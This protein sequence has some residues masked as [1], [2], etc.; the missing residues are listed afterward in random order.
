MVANESQANDPKAPL[1]AVNFTAEQNGIRAGE[2]SIRARIQCPDLRFLSRDLEA[3]Q[4]LQRTLL[5]LAESLSP[6][7]EHY[8]PDT[9][10]ID[11]AGCRPPTTWN[12]PIPH[13]RLVLAETPDLAHLAAMVDASFSGRALGLK[14]FDPLPLAILPLAGIPGSNTF[15]PVLRL[16]GLRSLG[17]FRR[18]PRQE[19][20][21]RIGPDAMHLHDV[22][23]GKIRRLLKPHH[24]IESFVQNIS[25]DSPVESLEA[26]IFQSNRMLQTLCARLKAS[27][28]AA[29][30]LRFALSFESSARMERT[31]VFPEPL[32]SPA[33]I[34]RP[35]HTALETLRAP[36]GIIAMELELKPVL[37]RAAQ[38]EWLGRQ[39]RQP[40]RWPDT[41]ARLNALLGPDRVGIPQPE[42]SHRSDAFSLHP[43]SGDSIPVS[44]SRHFPTS[45]LPLRRYRPP[46]EVAVASSA[47]GS[48]PQPLALLT[49]PHPGPITGLR[50]PFPLSGNWWKSSGAWQRLEWDIELNHRHLF[51]LVHVPPDQW[52]LD[53]AYT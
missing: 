17:E 44:K 47:H 16:W 35:L 14:D 51:R 40:T 27:H 41:L 9:L 8:R 10:I 50:G 25:L 2:S 39:L 20:A 42:D 4:T 19:I 11:L 30:T 45:P 32:S 34:L 37:P 23:H 22:L 7:F 36:S 46:L 33:A 28:R 43:A 21:E 52:L 18:L 1:L 31:L 26:L 3:E 38:R 29:G 53:G 12:P 13:L 5:E 49:G 6:D 48:L 24:A 15:L